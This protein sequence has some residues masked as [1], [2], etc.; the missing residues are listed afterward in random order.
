MTLSLAG[1]SDLLAAFAAHELTLDALRARFV[2]LL[3]ADP[4]GA[5]RADAT[6]WEHAP[7]DERLLWRLVHLYEH[8]LQDDDAAR[9]LAGRVVR[10]LSRT[11]SAG[12]TFELLPL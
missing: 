9:R 12:T 1:L 5:E 8:E 10:C 7:D 6:P 2:P 11:G 4:L 3:H